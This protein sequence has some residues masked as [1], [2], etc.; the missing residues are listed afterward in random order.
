[1]IKS[2]REF[3]VSDDVKEGSPNVELAKSLV[4]IA[5]LRWQ[6]LTKDI[7]DTN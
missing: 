3:I 6:N 7:T 2:F 5:K 4:R 1:M